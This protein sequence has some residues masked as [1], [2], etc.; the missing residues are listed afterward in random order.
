MIEFAEIKAEEVGDEGR[1]PRGGIDSESRMAVPKPNPAAEAYKVLGG[2]PTG[3]GA[4]ATDARRAFEQMFSGPADS[5]TPAEGTATGETPQE[6]SS[7]AAVLQETE[8][9]PPQGEERTEPE[10]T[11]TPATEPVPEEG[12]ASEPAAPEPA[13]AA[14]GGGDK[15][16]GE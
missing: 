16:T 13:N 7:E 2:K 8:S 9:A 5:G 6:E 12:E 3:P 11:E 10:N 1:T 14:A 15:Q 4:P